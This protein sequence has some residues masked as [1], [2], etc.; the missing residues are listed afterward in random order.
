MM[1]IKLFTKL[2]WFAAIT[3]C[4]VLSNVS[5]SA[6]P[7]ACQQS[8]GK[9][10]P[11][12]SVA[13]V[14]MAEA[15]LIALNEQLDAG[16]HDIRALLIVRDC[17][18]V[19]ERYADGYTRNHNHTVYSVTKSVTSTL[20]G[21]LLMQGKLK[22]VDVTVAQL[23]SKPW[24]MRETNWKKAEQITL[25]NVMQ[26]SSGLEYKHDPVN[27]SIYSLSA[28]RFAMALGSHFIVSPGTKFNYSD[29]DVSITGAMVAAAADKNLYRFAKEALFEPLRMANY[30][31][32]FM[33]AAGRYP[34][35]WG[36][37]LR[38]M[39]LAKLGQLYLQNG[40][41]NEARIFAPQYRE[42]AWTGGANPT[43]ALHWWVGREQ[44]AKSNPYYVA[45]GFKGQRLYVF[46]TLRLTV[47][48]IAS[49]PR[50]EEP[51]VSGMVLSGLIAAVE[52]T[53]PGNEGT[54]AA[55]LDA[56]QKRGF[57]GQTRVFQEDQDTPRR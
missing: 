49:L 7:G 27:N 26:M 6:E 3:A 32:A 24:W 46:P 48:L 29:G 18:L 25:K 47:V 30:D 2:S 11:S 35:G 15:P 20:V 13:D 36:L 44:E 9:D 31:W 51:Q 21:A 40:E 55:R 41:W 23:M 57:Q 1:K 8:V 38:P 45:R 43:Y 54:A 42:L 14:G 39:D 22:S 10:L 19:F 56:L 34:G 28:D 16:T 52:Q 50:A 53:F 12:S 5:H 17:K 4:T 33:D 37:R